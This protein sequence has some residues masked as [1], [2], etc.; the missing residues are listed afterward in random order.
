MRTILF[1][2]WILCVTILRAQVVTTFPSLSIHASSR[3]MGMGDAGI[4]SA[5][6]A[7]QLLYNPAKSAFTQYFHQVSVGYMPW[8]TG[9]SPDTRMMNVGYVASVNTAAF[10]VSLNYLNLGSI[11][12]RDDNGAT[13]SSYTAREYNV[14]GSFALQLNEHHALSTTLRFLAQN[15]YEPNPVNRYSVSGDV[16]YYGFTQIGESASRLEWGAT[17]SHLGSKKNNLP[18]TAA[19][20][21]A[22][23]QQM[24][25]HSVQVSVDAARLLKD[26][27]SGMRYTAGVEYGYVD[28]F[29]LRGGASIEKATA[30]NRKYFS[31]G[32]GYRGFVDDQGWQIDLHYLVPF[33]A[34]GGL[35]PYQGS[36]GLTIGFNLG[37][38]Q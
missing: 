15:A 28:Q 1:L 33:G 9:I 23:K 19:L 37:N 2:I 38:F 20:G 31:F 14:G 12:T 30:G 11:D 32:A 16:G 10:G 29:F 34:S 8:L 25:F 22:Y 7:Q 5:E 3:G 24:E 26:N 21:V 6:G 18:A 13:L 4:A 36:W 35:S 17:V 27:F